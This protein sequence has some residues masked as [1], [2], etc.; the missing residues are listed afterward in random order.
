M[1]A[2][3]SVAIELFVVNVADSTIAVSILQKTVSRWYL[4]PEK[5]GACPV[6]TF[7]NTKTKNKKQPGDTI[8]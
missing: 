2:K 6:I 4:V 7:Q 5:T 3:A 8:T 1:I